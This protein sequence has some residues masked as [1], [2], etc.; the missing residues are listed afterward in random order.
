MIK[1]HYYEQQGTFYIHYQKQSSMLAYL[2]TSYEQM[3]NSP[4]GLLRVIKPQ[5]VMQLLS[6]LYYIL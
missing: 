2:V 3:L 1:N 6:Y 5:L 4:M